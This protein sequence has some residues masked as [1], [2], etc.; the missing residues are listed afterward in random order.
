MTYREEFPDFDREPPA[1]LTG[2][3]DFADTSW[4]NDACPSFVC[5]VF[6]LWI[7]YVDQAKREHQGGPAY[8]LTDEGETVLETDDWEDVRAFVEDGRRD[9]PAYAWAASPL[10][11][12]AGEFCRWTNGQ[13]L[14]P[15]DAE[16]LLLR[17]LAVEQRRWISDF[18][19]RW[20]AAETTQE[21][22]A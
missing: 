2:D 10:D 12:L 19:V 6:V 5:D 15:V 22:G 4:H 7:D 17:E 18:V 11:Q 20:H 9:F 14:P 3:W 8:A 13:G 16:E 21:I 1:V